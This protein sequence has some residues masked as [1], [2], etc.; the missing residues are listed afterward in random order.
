VNSARPGEPTQSAWKYTVRPGAGSV[1]SPNGTL[2]VG[3]PLDPRAQLRKDQHPARAAPSAKSGPI[4][5]QPPCAPL[6]AAFGVSA[7]SSSQRFTSRYHTSEFWALRIQWFSSG[8]Y[9]KRVGTPRC[10]SAW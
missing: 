2:S 7:C 1:K 6:P 4:F 10:T 8:K 9:T 3:A 5:R